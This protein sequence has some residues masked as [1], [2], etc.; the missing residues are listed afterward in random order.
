M[1]DLID[2]IIKTLQRPSLERALIHG[3]DWSVNVSLPVC[4]EIAR[5]LK[6]FYEGD[7]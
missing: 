2:H 3:D 5:R 1:E 6:L 7:R 4:R